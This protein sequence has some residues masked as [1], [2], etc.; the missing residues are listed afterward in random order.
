M[1]SFN[2]LSS[3]VRAFFALW[4]LLLCVINIANA[5]MAFDKKKYLFGSI[6]IV[7]FLLFYGA[8]L[9]VF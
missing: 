9:S 3:L 1:V 5:V 6:G 2:M 8:V 4:A 7:L